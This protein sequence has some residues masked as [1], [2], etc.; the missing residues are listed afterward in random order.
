MRAVDREIFIRANHTQAVEQ[1]FKSLKVTEL[2]AIATRMAL[3][4]RSK[5]TRKADII[6]F[7]ISHHA[8]LTPSY[9]QPLAFWVEHEQ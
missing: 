2:K 6:Q 1:Q 9:E 5:V 8:P 7:L 3:P 4:N